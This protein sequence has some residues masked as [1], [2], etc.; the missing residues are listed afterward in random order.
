[1]KYKIEIRT[2]WEYGQRKDANGNPHQEDSLFPPHKQYQ[3]SDRVFILCDGMGGHEAGEV[4]SATVCEAMGK[5]LL[6]PKSTYSADD[7]RKAVNAAYDALDA[8]DNGSQGKGKMGTT[9]TCL[10]LHQN[11]ATLAHM[12]DSRIYHIRPGKEREDTQILFQTCD[13]SYVNDLVKVGAIKPE[14]AKNHPKKNIITRALQP[15]VENRE[16]PDIKEISNIK[17]GDWFYLCSDGMLEQMDDN[18]I[19]FMFSDATG[20]IDSKTEKLTQATYYNRDNHTAFIIHILE[21]EG[22]A[23]TPATHDDMPQLMGT[24]EDDPLPRQPLM[25]GAPETMFNK[26]PR[27]EG[28]NRDK[29][30]KGNSGGNT[31][32]NRGINPTLIKIIAIILIL[33]ILAVIVV[34]KRSSICTPNEQPAQIEHWQQQPAQV[35]H[36]NT[37]QPP[38]KPNTSKPS[39]KTNEETKAIEQELDILKKR[40]DSINERRAELLKK[41]NTSQQDSHEDNETVIQSE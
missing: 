35:L 23:P 17:A 22:S 28:N 20:D 9:M 30:P 11:G 31:S 24:I 18:N 37:T 12:G 25:Y 33:L 41:L 27:R 15:N 39:P 16:H 19:R 5:A 7:I 34:R 32:R 1:M 36:N 13:H 4:A 14:E 6:P 3:P 29:A 40:Q 2:I 8:I 38:Q 10:V 26:T 21:V